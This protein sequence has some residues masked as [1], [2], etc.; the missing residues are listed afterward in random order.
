[1]STFFVAFILYLFTRLDGIVE[2]FSVFTWLF[3]TA[4]GIASF[5]YIVWTVDINDAPPSGKDARRERRDAKLISL[6]KKFAIAA[7]VLSIL[8]VVTPSERD[9]VIIV[10]GTLGY[11]GVENVL[12][13]DFLRDTFGESSELLQEYL[14]A[15]TL[16]FRSKAEETKKA[17]SDDRETVTEE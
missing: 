14:N 9:M 11:K 15:K 8:N 4:L 16:E 17:L 7:I 10:G 6:I 5:V 2:F 3:A 1:M 12:E 13:S